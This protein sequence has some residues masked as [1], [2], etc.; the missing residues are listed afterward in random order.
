MYGP[1]DRVPL[2][3]SM[4]KLSLL[5]VIVV[6][7]VRGTGARVGAGAALI[8][9]AL[10]PGLGNVLTRTALP[11]GTLIVAVSPSLIA[12]G[13]V[14]GED[15]LPSSPIGI[16]PKVIPVLLVTEG[17]V[18]KMEVAAIIGC[19]NSTVACTAFSGSLL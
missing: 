18:S 5:T 3:I 12:T 16:P 8:I 10:P 15:Q 4:Q 6:D 2:E 17:A 9:A 1:T 11:A 14:L 19:M 13:L 7:T